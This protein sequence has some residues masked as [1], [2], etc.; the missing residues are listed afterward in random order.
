MIIPTI[1]GF[2][3]AQ[4]ITLNL[5][6]MEFS[7][8]QSMAIDFKPPNHLF[9]GILL[10]FTELGQES[11]RLFV[12]KDICTCTK[13]YTSTSTV[14]RTLHS[15]TYSGLTP[16]GAWWS[17]STIFSLV[18]TQPNISLES[19]WSLPGVWLPSRWTHLD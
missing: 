13:T 14:L 5:L 9:I 6:S 3:A 11:V 18:A 7:Y 8:Y 17:P 2:L 16:P 15:L 10:G 19:T 4:V 12:M 1:I